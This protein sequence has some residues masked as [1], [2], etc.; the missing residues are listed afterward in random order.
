MDEQLL[1]KDV[2]GEAL[3]IVVETERASDNQDYVVY[4]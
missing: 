1:K 4:H 3:E 2:L